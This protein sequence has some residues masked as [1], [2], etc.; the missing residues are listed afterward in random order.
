[1]SKFSFAWSFLLFSWSFLMVFFF[2][3]LFARSFFMVF[4]H[5]LISWSFSW[6]FLTV[7]SH[8]LCC[9]FMVSLWHGLWP[10]LFAK[11]GLHNL[12]RRIRKTMKKKD[13]DFKKTM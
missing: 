10:H 1:M 11:V 3:G 9:L 7:F 13:H 6:S 5:G 4:S 2:H 12:Y 8:G